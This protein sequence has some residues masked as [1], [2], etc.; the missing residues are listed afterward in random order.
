MNPANIALIVLAVG[1]VLFR[2]MSGR[3][4]VGKSLILLPVV[5]TVIG[6]TEFKG[7]M[8]ATAITFVAAGALLS[9]VIGGVRGLTV[10]LFERDGALWMRYRV[11]TVVLWAV[12]LLAKVA[13]M[14]VEHGIDAQ[15]ASAADKGILFALGLGI[16]AESLVVMGRGMTH[17]TPMIWAADRDGRPQSNEAFNSARDSLRR[18]REQ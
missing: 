11:V 10:K 8:S 7:G 6:A 12:N 17:Q 13:L 4:V 18:F 14:P 9:I 1:Y 16:L 15:A 3:P 2:R 5:L